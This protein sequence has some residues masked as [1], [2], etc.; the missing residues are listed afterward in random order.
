[1]TSKKRY[2]LNVVGPFYVED[3]CCASCG[4]PQTIAPALFA[5][6]EH[7]YEHCYV[8]RQP[9][10]EA[11]TDDMLRVIAAQELGCIRYGG[12]S[13]D[14]LRRLVERGEGHQCDQAAPPGA[15]PM[16]RDHVRFATKQRAAP[17]TAKELLERLLA[18]IAHPPFRST[19]IDEAA[20]TSASVSVSWYEHDYH[21]VEAC[22]SNG[23]ADWTVRHHG[24]P[25]LS[26]VIHD[27]LR[28]DPALDAARWQTREQYEAGGTSRRTPW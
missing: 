25:S 5:Q 19:P 12:A 23:S 26:D 22:A 8:R 27:W 16:R 10:T 13:P 14:I 2:A 11:E 6:N 7:E 28:Q 18:F 17:W 20:P 21:R 15:V 9:E 4:V 24:P 3:G 1:V